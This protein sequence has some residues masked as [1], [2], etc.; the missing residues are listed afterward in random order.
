[1]LGA[2]VTEAAA[3]I[4]EILLRRYRCCGCGAVITVGPWDIGARLL[5]GLL[6]V[7]SGA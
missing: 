1:M 3:A 2:I 4:H 7:V 5:Y 6:S